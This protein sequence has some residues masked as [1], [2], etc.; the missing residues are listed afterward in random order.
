MKI[1][2]LCF[3]LLKNRCAGPL[4]N[5]LKGE[6]LPQKAKKGTYQ[7]PAPNPVFHCQIIILSYRHILYYTPAVLITSA[8]TPEAVTS[9]PAPAPLITNGCCA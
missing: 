3:E 9:A 4:T 7:T 5:S 8:N 6:P 2:R 1:I